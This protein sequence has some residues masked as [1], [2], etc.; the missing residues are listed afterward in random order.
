M[1]ASDADI[2]KVLLLSVALVL[3]LVGCRMPT[4]PKYGSL[5]LNFSASALASKTLVP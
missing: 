3:L 5:V 4:M 1:S 2:R